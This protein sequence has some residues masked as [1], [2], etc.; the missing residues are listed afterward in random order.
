MSSTRA[1]Q[2]RHDSRLVGVRLVGPADAVAFAA[3]RVGL[4][5]NVVRQSRDYDSN[6]RSS[7]DV[8]RYLDVVVQGEALSA[9]QVVR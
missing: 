8:R 2:R 6:R 5:L 7:A 4:V 1:R 3:E 9:G